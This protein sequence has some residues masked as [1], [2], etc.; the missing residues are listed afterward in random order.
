MLDVFALF[1][2]KEMLDKLEN[3]EDFRT[4]FDKYQKLRL[5][6]EMETMVKA[7]SSD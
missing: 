5:Q 1:L 6:L 7:Q 4:A 2:C 3:S